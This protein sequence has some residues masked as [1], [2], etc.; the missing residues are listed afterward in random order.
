MKPTNGHPVLPPGIEHISQLPRPGAKGVKNTQELVAI[1][2][3]LKRIILEP[4]QQLDNK[5]ELIPV[6]AREV[7]ACARVWCDLEDLRLVKRGYG[8]PKPVE[9]VNG[10][11]RKRKPAPGSAWS[12]PSCGVPAPV[13]NANAPTTDTTSDK[14]Q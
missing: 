5:G 2:D 4:V 13:V 14:P 8:R 1:Q 9:A 12:E 10:Q 11:P 7:A 6:P 3:V